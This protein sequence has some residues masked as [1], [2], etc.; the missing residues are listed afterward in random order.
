MGGV[1]KAP[2]IITRR[3]VMYIYPNTIV[4]LL[5]NVPLDDSYSDTIFFSSL[6]SQTEHF[7]TYPSMVFN[8]QTYQRV[9]RGKIRLQVKADDIYDYNY[10]MF[11]NTSYGAKWFYAF[12]K[13]VEYINDA[14]SEIEF[15]I[16]VMQTWFF[17]YT[18]EP[19]Y[20]ERETSAT[21]VIGDN[22]APEPVDLG[23]IRCTKVNDTG[24]FDSYVAV[25][26]MADEED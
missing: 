10:L 2:P 8:N 20:V 11:Q 16:D 7:F 25:I 21:D 23:P 4:R 12:I 13:S 1:I 15:E 3:I 22:I 18:L 14:T 9:Q 17:D 6:Q 19:S 26:C 5:K 24:L